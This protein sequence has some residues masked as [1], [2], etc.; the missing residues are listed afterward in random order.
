V[1]TDTGQAEGL[2]ECDEAVM[3]GRASRRGRESN[4][5]DWAQWSATW[6]QADDCARLVVGTR[7]ESRDRKQVGRRRRAELVLEGM[8]ESCWA[9]GRR[10]GRKTDGRSK[11]RR[12]GSVSAEC[13]ERAAGNL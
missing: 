13:S 1:Q 2:E 12:R 7:S 4:N 11:G 5:I 10:A 8:R 3:A 6:G 9:Q